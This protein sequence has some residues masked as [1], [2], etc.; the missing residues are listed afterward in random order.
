MDLA[1]IGGLTLGIGAVLLGA[2]LEHLPLTAL[3][4]PS[5]FLIVVGGTFGAVLVSFPTKDIK[6][7]FNEGLKV[8]FNNVNLDHRG[9]IEEI[10][11]VA[12]LAR[13]EGILAVEGIRESIVDDRFRFALKYVIDGF[14]PA[15][16]TEILE[17]NI[18]ID[19]DEIE[20]SGKVW[21][22]AGGYSPTIGILGAVL[23]LIFVMQSLDNPDQIG[24]GIA[25]AFIA[26]IYGVGLANLVFIPLGTKIKRK[27]ALLSYHGEIIRVGINGIQEGLNPHFLRDKL[28]VFLEPDLRSTEES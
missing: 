25:V 1:T 8:A 28:E 24:S 3:Y 15:T 10:L 22:S 18:N 27:A 16:V 13:K 4:G 23:G 12:S 2:H 20:S 17:S 19:A 5:A 6:K 9:L 7:A 14:D 11:K 26:T 21:E